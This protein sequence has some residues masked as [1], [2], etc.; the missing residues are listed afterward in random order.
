[1]PLNQTNKVDASQN[2]QQHAATSRGSSDH[3]H[4]EHISPLQYSKYIHQF[5]PDPTDEA[6]NN[7]P[8]HMRLYYDVK[9][10]GVPNYLK[11]RRPVPSDLN[12]DAWQHA[13]RDYHDADIVNY[14]RYGWPASYTAP[15]PPT[16]SH[17]NHP[18]ALRHPTAVEAFIDKEI[19]KQALLGPFESP[20]FDT[21]CQIS[22]LMTRDKKGEDGRTTGKRVIVDLSYPLG[23][24]VNSGIDRNNFQGEYRSYSLPTPL[25]LAK[26]IIESGPGCFLWKSDL[27]RAYRQ[28][29]VD[30]LDYPLLGIQYKGQTYIDICPSF[31]CRCSGAAQQRVSNALSYIMA[32]QGQCLLAYVDDFAGIAQ[33][34]QQTLKGLAAFE[35]TCEKLGLKLAPGKTAFPSTSM[36]WLGFHFDTIDM[37]ITIPEQKLTDLLEEA[38]RWMTKTHASRNEYQSLAG[39]LNHVNNVIA[40]ARK[41][42]GRILAALREAPPDRATPIPPEVTKG[43]Q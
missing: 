15:T 8:Y 14:L 2:H 20:P 31:G 35:E 42:M 33:T 34:C 1:M 9:Q 36:Q 28:L 5:W 23:A 17:R 43:I 16:A 22:P 21:W 6:I 37:S 7:A 10:S 40:P 30:P 39:K 12:T 3:P 38:E 32:S 13:L 24:S 18:S 11:G 4:T 19:H 26:L 29:R 25:D 27:E 41:F